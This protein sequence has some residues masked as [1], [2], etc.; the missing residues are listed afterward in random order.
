MR[1][2]DEISAFDARARSRMMNCPECGGL[3]LSCQCRKKF[4]HETRC[5]EACIP[6][7]FWWT[8]RK[9]I[10]HNEEIFD[11]IV[12]PYVKKIPRAHD[13]GAGL[14]L[15]GDNGCGKTIFL[16]W[17]LS[18]I[19]RSGLYTCYYTTM[20]QLAK[21]IGTTWKSDVAA[22]RLQYYQTSDF[23]VIDEL[24]KEKSKL[25][26]SFARV[27]LERWVKN[28]FDNK[29]PTL[30]ASNCSPTDLADAPENG[31]YGQ[32]V[33][34]VIS[35][36]CKVIGMEPGDFR[37]QGLRDEVGHEMGWDD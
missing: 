19:A 35:G 27:E 2:E 13:I 17:I 33:M 6:E 29:Q 31:G 37:Q 16:S 4:A 28:R 9:H 21:D 30:Y 5:Y 3:S 22:K 25:G 8:E 14:F 7:S 15:Y 36:R 10:R 18:R 11:G 20:P 12:V 32:T 26:D 34:S 24:G 1:T 23:V